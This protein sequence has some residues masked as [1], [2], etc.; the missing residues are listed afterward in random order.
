MTA[1]A[2]NFNPVRVT[3]TAKATGSRMGVSVY[4]GGADVRSGEAFLVDAIT[5]GD[6]SD[7]PPSA[8][9]QF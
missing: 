9:C 7:I 1:D 5:V 8:P 3:G 6:S 2:D 4:R